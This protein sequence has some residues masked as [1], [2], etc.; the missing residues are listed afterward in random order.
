LALPSFQNAMSRD[1]GA[2]A[3]DEQMYVSLKFEG[4][5]FQENEKNVIKTSTLHP[6]SH[7]YSTVTDLAK[8]LGWSTLCP[9][10]T[11]K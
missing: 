6:R 10:N 5:S 2:R 4:K 1:E 9:L 11:V 8:F 7:S 3:T